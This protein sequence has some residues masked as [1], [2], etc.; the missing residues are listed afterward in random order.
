VKHRLESLCVAGGKATVTLP[1]R[2]AE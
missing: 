2:T 1:Q